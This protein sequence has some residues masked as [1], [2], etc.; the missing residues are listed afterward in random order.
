LGMAKHIVEQNGEPIYFCCDG[1]KIKFDA[2]PEKYQKT[3]ILWH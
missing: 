3:A 1:C 2:E